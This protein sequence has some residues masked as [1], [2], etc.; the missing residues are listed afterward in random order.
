MMRLPFSNCSR[1]L[2]Q[3]FRRG[4]LKALGLIVS[5]AMLVLTLHQYK[6]SKRLE[7][8]YLQ[9]RQRIERTKADLVR[10]REAMDALEKNLTTF[11]HKD[12]KLTLTT[13]SLIRHWRSDLMYLRSLLHPHDTP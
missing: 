13:D 4:L 9:A 7:V 12:A 11:A 6:Q 1:S 10:A 2:S 8:K 5:L 3:K